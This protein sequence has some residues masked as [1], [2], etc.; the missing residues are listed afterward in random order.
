AVLYIMVIMMGLALVV[1]L[2]NSVSG[3]GTQTLASLVVMVAVVL[4]GLWSSFMLSR[5]YLPLSNVTRSSEVAWYML[6]VAPLL[7]IGIVF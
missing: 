3:S 1:S 5:T 2:R 6:G 7:I 4:I